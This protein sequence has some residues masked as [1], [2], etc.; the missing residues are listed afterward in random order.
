M[1]RNPHFRS[2][3]RCIS[4]SQYNPNTDIEIAHADHW[5]GQHISY[6]FISGLLGL[7]NKRYED[8]PNQLI[9]EIHP[10][11]REEVLKDGKKLF[12]EMKKQYHYPKLS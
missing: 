1:L 5:L 9:F 7:A 4:L 8:A 10:Q 6:P 3:L 12:R 2:L 11:Q